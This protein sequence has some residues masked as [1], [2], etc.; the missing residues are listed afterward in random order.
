MSTTTIDIPGGQATLRD[1]L[2]VNGQELMQ[3]V[4]FGIGKDTKEKILD[5][6]AHKD[7]EGFEPEI[8]FEQSM[9]MSRLNRAA[10]I[11]FLKSWT[12]DEPLPTLDSLGD[13]PA[14][15]F[16]TLMQAVA[17]RGADAVLGTGEFGPDG[18]ADPNSPTVTSSVS[19]PRLK[20]SAARPKT[21]TRK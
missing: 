8:T 16:N 21:S 14:G 1:E 6:I 20:V 12:L 9:A 5:L 19:A 17:G 10:V 4:T 2:T 15:L 3:A 18:S 11:A 7:D 13:L